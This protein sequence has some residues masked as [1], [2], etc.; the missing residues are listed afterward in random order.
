MN[1]PTGEI[2][3]LLLAGSQNSDQTL[4][5]S[6]LGIHIDENWDREIAEGCTCSTWP[7]TY[8]QYFRE[9]PKAIGFLKVKT[10]EGNNLRKQSRALLLG[11][12]QY[13]LSKLSMFKLPRSG[14]CLK[15]E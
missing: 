9:E 8:S 14:Y 6:G 11:A 10:N 7:M 13:I 1:A 12:I 5:S 2:P 3:I 15:A 4:Q